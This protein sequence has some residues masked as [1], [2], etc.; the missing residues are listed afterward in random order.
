VAKEAERLDKGALNGLRGLFAFHVM[1]F[2]ACLYVPGDVE[3]VVNLY[4]HVDMPL[5]FLLSGFSLALAYGK[6]AWNGSTR[7]CFG[8]KTKTLDGID[9][10]SPDDAPKIFDSWEFYKKRLIRIFPVL[11]LSHVL[12]LIVWKFG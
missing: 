11:Y 8:C 12:V 2:H 9:I 10:E 4:A 5:F 1:A 3:P 7:F 6:T